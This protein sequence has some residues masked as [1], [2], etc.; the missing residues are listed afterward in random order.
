MPGSHSTYKEGTR[1]SIVGGGGHPR[2]G[3][4]SPSLQGRGA[5]PQRALPDRI[6]LRLLRVLPMYDGDGLLA[7]LDARALL[8]AAVQPVL[9]I[10]TG[11]GRESVRCSE[12]VSTRTTQLRS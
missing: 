6:I 11:D 2:G 9:P 1:R 8:G 5:S 7:W 3:R 10:G 4:A 12:P